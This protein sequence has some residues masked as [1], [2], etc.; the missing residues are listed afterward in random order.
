MASE[1]K[2]DL[3]PYCAKGRVIKRVE[4]IKFRRWST[5]GYIHCQVII[6][7][8]FCDQCHSFSVDPG[9]DE[10]F[11]KAFQQEFEKQSKKSD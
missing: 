5:K 6:P 8:G 9:A 10:I 1:H 3:C 2:I 11:E 4:A 7:V